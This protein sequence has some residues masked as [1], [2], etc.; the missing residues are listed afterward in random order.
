MAKVKMFNVEGSLNGETDLPKC[1]GADIRDDLIRK[2]F[3]SFSNRQPYGSFPLAGQ[4]YSASGIFKHKRRHYKSAYGIGISRIPRKIMSVRGTRFVRVGATIP[5]TRGGRQAHPPKVGKIWV[6]ELNKKEKEIAFESLIASTASPDRLKSYY[7]TLDFSD[8]NLPL[9]VEEKITS[10]DK[11]KKIK[12]LI[13]KI[14]GKSGKDFDK[15]KKI[16][17]IVSKNSPKFGHSGI[18]FVKA[19]ELSLQD[20]A[21]YGKTGRLVLYTDGALEELKEKYK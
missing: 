11:T 21:P 19:R 8:V 4:L 13:K 14:L 3:R 18:E 5:G 17:L 16:V 10:L 9:V 2:A 15:S 1:F 12:E 7:P 20:L 6:G